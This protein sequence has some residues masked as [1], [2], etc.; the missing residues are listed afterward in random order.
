MSDRIL[1][2]RKKLLYQ[3]HNRGC[4]EGDLILGKFAQKYLDSMTETELREFEQIL[5]LTDAD[6][7]DWYCQKAELPQQHDSKL[8][9]KLLEFKTY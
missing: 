8:M 7:Y 5:Q 3:S 4:K 2:L 9:R 1:N 6:I